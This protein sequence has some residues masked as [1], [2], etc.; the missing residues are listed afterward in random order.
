MSKPSSQRHPAIAPAHPGLVVREAI[1][2]LS[3]PMSEAAR[4]LGVTCASLSN[5][6]E[7]KCAIRDEIA[8]RIERSLS[9][10]AGM[11]LRMQA[12]HDLWHARAA[13]DRTSSNGRRLQ[14]RSPG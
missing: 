13:L 11:L 9:I 5:V 7:E 1:E 3:L 4:Q 10:S 6:V 2:S 14:R 8:E 12:A